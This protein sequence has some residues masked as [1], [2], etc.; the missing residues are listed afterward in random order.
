MKRIIFTLGIA[1]LFTLQAAAQCGKT[2]PKQ[3]GCDTVLLSQTRNGDY[4][5]SKYLVKDKTGKDASFS[6]YYAINLSNIAKTFSD[7]SAQLS[8]MSCFIGSSS[9]SLMHISS[10]FVAGYSSPDGNPKFNAALAAK[11][12]AALKQYVE[13]NYRPAYG[14]TVTSKALIWKD[15]VPAV[16]NS[17]ISDRGEV[18]RIL[19]SGYSEAEK[20]R[21]LRQMPEAWE[22]LKT[23][24]LPKMRY[25]T[26]T[27]DYKKDVV[28]DRTVAVQPPKPAEPVVTEQPQPK[29]QPVMIIEEE[30]TGIVIDVRPEDDCY[31]R[32]S[33]RR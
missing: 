7:N 28:I 30:E 22:Y 33:R 11:R 2:A 29:L 21:H 26:A 9:D 32:R 4:I 25:A 15:C 16:E 24:V 10:A 20:E 14:V 18:L 8:D 5:V 17:S 31:D 23:E 6:V 27:F 12:A 19:S 13:T 1:L 3:C